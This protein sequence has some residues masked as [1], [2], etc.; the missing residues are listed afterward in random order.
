M[1]CVTVTGEPLKVLSKKML[2]TDFVSGKS[3]WWQFVEAGERPAV[4]GL[5]GWLVQQPVGRRMRTLTR[6]WDRLGV[7][8]R[9]SIWGALSNCGLS[10]KDA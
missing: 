3:F 10:N 7:I 8:P 1:N 4:E 9:H 5:A 2:G 6:V